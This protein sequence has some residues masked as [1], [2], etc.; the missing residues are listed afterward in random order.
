M[1]ALETVYSYS[2]RC[3]HAHPPSCAPLVPDGSPQGPGHRLD[4]PVPFRDRHEAGGRRRL[5]QPRPGCPRRAPAA[6]DPD[7]RAAGARHRHRQRLAGHPLRPVDQPVPW[8]RAWLHL[9]LRAADAQLS[10]PVSRPGLRDPHRRQG[11]CR[12]AAAGHARAACLPPRAAEYRLGDRRL[13]ARRATTAH[14]PWRARGAGPSAAPAVD[15]HQV[16]GRR[17]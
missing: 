6:G 9:L 10:R 15:R 12:R 16:L 1:R 3:P 17:A 2:I 13:P 4:H 7:R 8:L 5:G 14:H 11:E